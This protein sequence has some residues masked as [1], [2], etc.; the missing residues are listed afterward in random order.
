MPMFSSR[1][2][3]RSKAG[4]AEFKTMH[5]C[6]LHAKIPTP[7]EMDSTNIQPQTYSTSSDIW[8]LAVCALEVNFFQPIVSVSRE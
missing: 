5:D 1:S 3:A 2:Q 7:P 8:H 6:T 4:R